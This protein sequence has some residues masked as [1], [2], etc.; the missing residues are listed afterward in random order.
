MTLNVF[1][2]LHKIINQVLVIVADV[3]QLIFET[4]YVNPF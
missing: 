4:L 2:V 3:L 1:A